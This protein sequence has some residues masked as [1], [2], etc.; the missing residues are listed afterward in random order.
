ME[1][2]IRGRVVQTLGELIAP[3][4]RGKEIN[5]MKPPI[6]KTNTGDTPALGKRRNAQISVVRP[7]LTKGLK[8]DLGGKNH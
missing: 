3:Q 1:L 7:S 8:H 4:K 5:A 6:L 2:R